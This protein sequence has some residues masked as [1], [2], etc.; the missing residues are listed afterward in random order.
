MFEPTP[1]TP[2]EQ[3]IKD[4]VE[5]ILAARGKVSHSEGYQPESGLGGGYMVYTKKTEFKKKGLTIAKYEEKLDDEIC[6]PSFAIWDVGT[7]IFGRFFNAIDM[8]DGNLVYDFKIGYKIQKFERGPWQK[9]LESLV[10]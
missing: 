6:T 8:Y 4:N 5:K 1:L 9:R 2:E 7:G 10:I 3:K